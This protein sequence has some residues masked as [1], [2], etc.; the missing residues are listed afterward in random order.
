[1]R[2]AHRNHLGVPR[3]TWT[4]D[5]GVDLVRRI[6]ARVL[7]EDAKPAK[8]NG[9]MNWTQHR[10]Q[11]TQFDRPDGLMREHLPPGR[12][13]ALPDRRASSARRR[14]RLG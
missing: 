7:P 6:L 5:V 9:R 4:N 12:P 8:N 2:T 3:G 10:C 14:E 11:E 1:M 13:L